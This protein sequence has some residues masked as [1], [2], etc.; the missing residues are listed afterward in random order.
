MQQV[1]GQ[2]LALGTSGGLNNP[3]LYS[4][5][6]NGDGVKEMIVFDRDGDRWLA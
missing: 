5:D 4:V 1:S 6:L 3:Q 2:V